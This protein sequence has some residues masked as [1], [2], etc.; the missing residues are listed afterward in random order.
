M[1]SVHCVDS[2][3]VFPFCEHLH[4]ERKD[5]LNQRETL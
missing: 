1:K 2:V 5:S 3:D 4:F